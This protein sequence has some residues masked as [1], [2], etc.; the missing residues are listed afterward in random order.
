MWFHRA[1]GNPKE[2]RAGEVGVGQLLRV[3]VVVVFG[4]DQQVDRGR[5]LDPHLSLWTNSLFSGP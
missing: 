3:E 2:G 4:Q 5:R 1:V